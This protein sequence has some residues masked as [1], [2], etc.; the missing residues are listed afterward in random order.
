MGGGNERTRKL[1]LPADLISSQPRCAGH[2][3]QPSRSYAQDWARALRTQF[4]NCGGWEG[5]QGAE[6]LCNSAAFAGAASMGWSRVEVQPQRAHLSAQRPLTFCS[7]PCGSTWWSYRHEAA[8]RYSRSSRVGGEQHQ[9]SGLPGM[10]LL[11]QNTSGT[12]ARRDRRPKQGHAAAERRSS[13][14]ARGLG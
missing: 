2:C 12:A 8:G 3:M 11:C 9:G 14:G 4:R 1:Q 13:A 6:G 10:P 5:P 7:G